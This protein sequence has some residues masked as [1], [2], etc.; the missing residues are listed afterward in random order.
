V[1][2]A[3][4]GYSGRFGRAGWALLAWE[5]MVTIVLCT[6]FASQRF[7]A[8]SSPVLY[9]VPN[10]SLLAHTVEQAGVTVNRID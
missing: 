4:V 2:L 5:M 6:L 8:E 3:V 10:Y 1:W 7:M 9:S